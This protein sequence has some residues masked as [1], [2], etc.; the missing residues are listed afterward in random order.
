MDMTTRAPLEET[1]PAPAEVS[2]RTAAVARR[3]FS[4]LERLL[5]VQAASGAV[6]LVATIGALALASSPWGDA[7]R[8]LLA[9]PVGLVLGPLR[10]V[11]P[12]R[13]WIDEAL[14]TIFF[15]VAGLE[16]RR[17]IHEGVLSSVRRAALPLAAAI[18]GMVAPSLLYL[19]LAWGDPVARRGWA[20]PMATDVAFALGALA[21]L[22]KRAPRELRVLLLALAMIDDVGASLVITAF[23]SDPLRWDGV[24]V[25]LAAVGVV[26]FMRRA[27]ARRAALY[28]V[29]GAVL[30]IGMLR[31]GIH[32]TMA[33]IVLGLLTPARAWLGPDALAEEART[34]VERVVVGIEEPPRGEV[35]AGLLAEETRHLERVRREALA[36]ATRLLTLLD[37]WVAFG[38]VP[39][40][41]FTNAG[42]SLRALSGGPT[43]VTLGVVVG[44]V[45]GKP[46][47]IV[48]AAWAATRLRAAV[49]PAEVGLRELVVLGLVAGVGFTMSLFIGA[50]AFPDDPRL[51][52]AKA[53]ILAA[54]VVASALALVVG[55]VARRRA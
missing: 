15:F 30:W 54:S 33:G 42:V 32:P 6:L 23:Y 55:R 29:P 20:V 24:V 13:F 2:P 14:M 19:A 25:A 10:A 12:A 5:H 53:A 7:Y 51:E 9:A 21:L 48:A 28:V 35:E 17:E 38:V 40:F 41:A 3:L 16:I 11:H 31:A 47:G 46:L 45:V 44:L 52:E 37:P 8:R 36:P 22:G 26:L 4:P 27:G 39:L 49:L 1:R 18:G 34:T 50:L 43:A